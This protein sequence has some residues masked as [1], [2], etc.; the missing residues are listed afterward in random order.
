MAKNIYRIPLYIKELTKDSLVTAM[1][2]NNIKHDKEFNYFDIQQ[3]KQFWVAWYYMTARVAPT[4]VLDDIPTVKKPRK[5]RAK[6]K[7]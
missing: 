3:E 6:K 1:A 2:E 4:P 7:V 5:P